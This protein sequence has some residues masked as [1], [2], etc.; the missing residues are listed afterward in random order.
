MPKISRKIKSEVLQL[1][2]TRFN[3]AK[4]YQTPIFNDFSEYYELYRS[5]YNKN[6]Q[7]YN[8]RANLFIPIVYQTIE[9]IVPRMVAS[10]PKLETLPTKPGDRVN[11]RLMDQVLDWQY[12]NG[13]WKRV[14]KSWVRETLM[15]G[16]GFVK[17]TWDFTLKKPKIVIKDIF[18]MWIDPTSEN[19]HDGWIIES[20]EMNIDDIRDNEK[21]DPE[22]RKLVY[23]QTQQNEYQIRRDSVKS[24]SKP[25]Q[26][27]KK[28]VKLWQHWMPSYDMDDGQGNKPAVALVANGEFVLQVSRN[29][30]SHARAP[31]SMIKDTD[32]PNEFWAIGEIEPLKSLQYELNDVRN[33]RMDNVSQII[34]KKWIIANN[35]GINEKELRAAPYGIVHAN[36]TT[37]AG[38]RQIKEQDVTASA[39]QEEQIIKN[40][41]QTTSGITDPFIGVGGGGTKG[42]ETATGLALLQE[43]AGTRIKYKIDNF[44]DSLKDLGEQVIALNQQYL[45]KDIVIR[46]VGEG[47]IEWK[48]I[49]KKDIMNNFDLK[50]TAGSQ[51]ANNKIANRAEARELL[52]TIAPFAQIAGVDLSP[53]LK[54]IFD[55][56]GDIKNVEEVFAQ[57]QGAPMPEGITPQEVGGGATGGQLGGTNPNSGAP[58]LEGLA[59]SQSMGGNTSIPIERAAG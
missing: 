12:Y 1:T 55:T 17:T 49:S 35:S 29:P 33:Q 15:Y 20:T 58:Q 18:D 24:L 42:G 21:F 22:E 41:A 6:K 45:P 44:E 52:A 51:T 25:K 37:D 54:Y 2:R 56:Y 23:I 39:Y 38:I 48:K 57:V 11:A 46:I 50:V 28:M 13:N 4:D 9:N 7:S 31:Y 34:H 27:D 36:D 10:K 5:F 19:I 8:G 59:S 32:V 40:D 53:I 43:A 14:F 47:G 16:N 3:Q 30:F 26:S